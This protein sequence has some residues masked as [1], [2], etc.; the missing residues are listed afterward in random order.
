MFSHLPLTSCLTLGKSFLLS[1]SEKFL[2]LQSEG[3][4]GLARK[5]VWV[6]HTIFDINLNELLANP[7]KYPSK[8]VQMQ[9]S[10]RFQKREKQLSHL[11]A[12]MESRKMVLA[13][14]FAGQNR[15]TD[16]EDRPRAQRGRRGWEELKQH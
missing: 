9:I 5:F 6:F 1:C 12:Y 14:L 2:H 3:C 16:I 8:I 4:I 7:I 10:E 13:D 11:N 15:G